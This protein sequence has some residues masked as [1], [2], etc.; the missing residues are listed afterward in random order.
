MTALVKQQIKGLTDL[1]KKNQAQFEKVLPSHVKM[2]RL[3]RVSQSAFSRNPLLAE[4]EPMSMLNSIMVS[5]QLGLEVNTPMGSAY[6][7][8]YNN[9]KTGKRE[10]QLI[11]GYRGLIEL[12]RRSGNI[13]SIESRV[14]YKNDIFDLEFGLEPKLVHKPANGDRGQW[15]HVYAIAKL[16][17]GGVQYEV[18]DIHQV[19]AIRNKSQGYN[20]NKPYGPWHDHEEEMAR[21][22]VIRRLTKYLPISIEL[23]QAQTNE[24]RLANGESPVFGDEWEP[25][26]L[27]EHST[28]DGETVPA[29][30]AD[31]VASKI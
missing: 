1:I 12:C 10:A 22:T 17:D 3:M 14:V 7:V 15:T 26:E 25:L 8:P 11:I 16:K 21:K 24:D 4:C 9:R 2:E 5:S 13:I 27:A 28:I 29:S 23:A 30:K 18:M 19:H 31:Q 20:P 6:L